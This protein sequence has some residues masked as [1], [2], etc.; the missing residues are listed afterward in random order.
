MKKLLAALFLFTTINF[1]AQY[2][3]S[4]NYVS[5]TPAVILNVLTGLTLDYDVQTYK[6]IYNTVDVNGQPTIASGAFI[7][8]STNNCDEFPIAVY[9]HG[10]SLKKTDFPSNFSAFFSDSFLG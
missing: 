10:T 6:M 3:V 2:L 8:P 7:I 1:S 4:C 9:L 5:S